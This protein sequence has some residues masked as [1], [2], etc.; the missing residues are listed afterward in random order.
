MRDAGNRPITA[1]TRSRR[2]IGFELADGTLAS[3]TMAQDFVA[4]A[5][6]RAKYTPTCPERIAPHDG[7]CAFVNRRHFQYHAR[8]MP[9]WALKPVVWLAKNH[10]VHA[11]PRPRSTPN[12]I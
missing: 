6:G 9:E 7:K 4:F 3:Y 12:P 10:R 1:T 5:D 2:E 11:Y 8:R